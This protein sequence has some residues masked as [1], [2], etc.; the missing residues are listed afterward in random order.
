MVDIQRDQR[1]RAHAPP[2]DQVDLSGRLSKKEEA[3][4]LHMAQTRLQQLRL[5]VGGKLGSGRLGPP[6]T[7]VF[8]GWDA[9][10]KGGTI[11]RLVGR[12]DPRHFRVVQYGAPTE[13]ELRHHWL[14]R[15]WPLLPGWGGMAVYDRSW[16]GR[17]LVERVEAF[18]AE[19]DWRRAY[20][21]IRE[22]ERTLY[23]EGMTLIKY[24]LHI[25]DEEQFRRFE[26][27]RVNQLKS[28]KLTEED[29]RN[30]AKRQYY[31]AAIEEMFEETSIPEAPWIVVPS[32]NKRYGRVYA[33]EIAIE[34]IEAGMRRHGM[35][36][37]PSV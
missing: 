5:Q 19:N 12:M 31:E 37:L 26:A 14:T 3:E 22:F 24:W 36:P 30:R 21:E 11:K 32:E 28:Y 13:D 35:E 4:R 29:W 7:F 17:V 27:R 16:Y 8:E 33:L 15:F 20:K 10:G 25:S 23:A 6:L 34:M 2:L 9:A 1:D 18:A